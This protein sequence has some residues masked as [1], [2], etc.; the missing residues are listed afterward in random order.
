MAQ[1]NKD[2]DQPGPLM[3]ETIKLI[4]ETGLEKVAFVT[5]VPFGWIQKLC[6]GTFKNPSVNR[7]EHIYQVLSGSKIIGK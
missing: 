3:I 7:I 1:K 5:L 6:S 4:K 2:Y